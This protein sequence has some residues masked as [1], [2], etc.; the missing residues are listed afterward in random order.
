MGKGGKRLRALRLK[1]RVGDPTEGLTCLLCHCPTADI[2]SPDWKGAP[3][4]EYE[5]FFLN[6]GGSACAGLHKRCYE[7]AMRGT[8]RTSR[9]VE[10]R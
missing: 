8:L 10:A 3:G 5:V 7:M 2:G 4:C 9:S 6:L 1:V